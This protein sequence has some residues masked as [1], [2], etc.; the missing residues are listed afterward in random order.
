MIQL[1]HQVWLGNIKSYFIRTDSSLWRKVLNATA[2]DTLPVEELLF[3][4]PRNLYE[5]HQFH[6]WTQGGTRE[7]KGHTGRAQGELTQGE[8]GAAR[9]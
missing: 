2:A 7:T 4:N 1:W 5:S 3:E 9:A 6:H 8:Q